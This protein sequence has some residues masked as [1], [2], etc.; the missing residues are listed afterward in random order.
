M[1]DHDTQR[2]D[3]RL[4][5]AEALDRARATTTPERPLDEVALELVGRGLSGMPVLDGAWVNIGAWPYCWPAPP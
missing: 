1:S 2:P 4:G 5:I 3:D